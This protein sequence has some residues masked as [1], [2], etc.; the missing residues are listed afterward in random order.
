[1][2]SFQN[3]ADAV[4]TITTSKCVKDMTNPAGGNVVTGNE[5]K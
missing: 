5:A 1:M 3:L 4:T 2:Q